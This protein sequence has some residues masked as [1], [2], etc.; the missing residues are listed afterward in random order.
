MIAL[1]PYI[2]TVDGSGVIA[3]SNAVLLVNSAALLQEEHHYV[4]VNTLKKLAIRKE[5]QNMQIDLPKY[6]VQLISNDF[7]PK[8]SS[9][10]AL[11]KFMRLQIQILL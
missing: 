4:A 5:V 2:S 1:W 9:W 7:S 8:V 3:V 11:V 6:C 10:M